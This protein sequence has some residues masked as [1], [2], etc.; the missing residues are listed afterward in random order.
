[1][2]PMSFVRNAAALLLLFWMVWQFF[3]VRR[4]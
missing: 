4:H 3:V 2:I 1:M